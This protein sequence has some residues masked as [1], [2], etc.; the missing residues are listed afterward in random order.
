MSAEEL[1]NLIP[2]STFSDLSAETKV[3]HQVKK[4]SGEIIFRLILFSMLSSE[5]IS[6][7][8][9][10][11]LI[12]S[13]RFKSFANNQT[14][15]SKF[16]SIRD[17]ICNINEK[18]FEE[19]FHTIFKIYNKHLQQEH[20]LIKAD[21]TYVS[22]ASKLFAQGMLNGTKAYGKKHVKFSVGLKG[23]LPCHVRVH[24]DQP[25]VSEDLALSD[26]INTTEQTQNSIVV[27]DRGLQ[28]RKVF[29]GFSNTNKLF[30]GRCNLNARCKTTQTIPASNKPESSSI[31]IASDQI[32]FLIGRR[33]PTQNQFRIIKGKINQT[34]EPI[35]LV[36]NLLDEDAYL[37][38]QLYKQRWEIEVFFKFLKQNLN[39]NHLVSRNMNG[40]KVMIYMTLILSTLII[41]YKKLNQIAGFKIANLKFEIE[42]EN[43]IIKEIV[44]LCGGNPQL[45]QHLWNS[46]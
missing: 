19:L 46:S 4:L 42:L 37:I 3:D 33:K 38:A 8:V 7:R 43:S 36:T 39:L 32:G 41:V 34:N 23:S 11:S 24:V 30:I 22:V 26:L 20:A 28:S 1:I 27:F 9:M 12:K 45:A 15:N 2:K 31:T 6:L 16:N 14:I 40:I 5:K 17:R 21:S 44:K 35:A 13:T 29:E 25:F 18:Y 10:E